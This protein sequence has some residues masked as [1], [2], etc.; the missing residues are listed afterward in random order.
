MTRRHGSLLRSPTAPACTFETR[1]PTSPFYHHLILLFAVCRPYFLLPLF[2]CGG[3]T[4]RRQFGKVVRWQS[5]LG[6]WSLPWPWG[7]NRSRLC[8]LRYECEVRAINA[9]T[10][11]FLV[12]LNTSGE[13]YIYIYNYN[14]AVDCL[15]VQG[16]ALPTLAGAR[17]SVAR[18]GNSHLLVWR[19]ALL[20]VLALN[21]DVRACGE[22]K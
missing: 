10:P 3:D 21:A 8:P 7:V 5:C 16:S 19:V 2:S 17:I 18:L 1:L 15:W 6:Y 4:Y 14:A 12:S 11:P 22:S 20:H 9:A 13:R